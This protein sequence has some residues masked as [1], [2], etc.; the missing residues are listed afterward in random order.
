MSWNDLWDYSTNQNWRLSF[1]IEGVGLLFVFCNN[2]G[3]C[4]YQKD[5]TYKRFLVC[6]SVLHAIAFNV[7]CL[8]KFSVYILCLQVKSK[9]DILSLLL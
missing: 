2:N 6:D 8:D 1:V 3:D 9:I 4:L 7:D 5:S